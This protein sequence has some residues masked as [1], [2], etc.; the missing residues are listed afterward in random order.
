MEAQISKFT[1]FGVVGFGASCTLRS[2][3][4]I[5]LSL[6][7][8]FRASGFPGRLQAA[9]EGSYM[10]MDGD[11]VLSRKW[12]RNRATTFYDRVSRIITKISLA[13]T[14]SGMSTV[15]DRLPLNHYAYH[16]EAYFRYPVVQLGTQIISD[17]YLGKCLGP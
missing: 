5:Q 4:C 7:Y 8:S 6:G 13:Q 10:G 16:V 1:G 3:L 2:I 12:R 9:T 17:P 14:I 15:E 11:M